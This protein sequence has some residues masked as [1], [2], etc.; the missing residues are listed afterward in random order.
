MVFKPRTLNSHPNWIQE[1]ANTYE[2]N[3]NMMFF[4]VWLS[5]HSEIT[6][7]GIVVPCY[8]VT[9]LVATLK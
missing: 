2:Q 8:T 5:L 6:M 1:K 9:A 3:N 7:A 4:I